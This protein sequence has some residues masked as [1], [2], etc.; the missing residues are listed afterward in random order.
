[1][2]ALCCDP[3]RFGLEHAIPMKEGSHERWI[4][5]DSNE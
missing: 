4:D 5:F 3:F 2:T 1:M